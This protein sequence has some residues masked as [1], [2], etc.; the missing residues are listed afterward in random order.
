MI[1]RKS[2]FIINS[3]SV[4]ICMLKCLQR[5]TSVLV[6]GAQSEYFI[7]IISEVF[8]TSKSLIGVLYF[9]ILSDIDI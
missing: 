2:I 3:F 5:S 1:L 4:T 6:L 9:M 8:K 7:I